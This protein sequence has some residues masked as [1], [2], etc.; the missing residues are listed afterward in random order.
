[1]DFADCGSYFSYDHA[2]SNTP[3][4]QELL[5]F[6]GQEKQINI[7]QEVGTQYKIFGTF[8][9]ENDDRA[10]LDNLWSKLWSPC[11]ML[12]CTVVCATSHSFQCHLSSLHFAVWATRNVVCTCI[13]NYVRIIRLSL[14][15]LKPLLTTCC[16]NLIRST[17]HFPWQRQ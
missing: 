7:P 12:L 14:Q 13:R 8:L 10:K 16:C 5:S 4:L 2:A 11:W 17:I 1:M 3:T 6:P 9:L 15:E